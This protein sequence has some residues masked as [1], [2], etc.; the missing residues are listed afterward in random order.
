M[1]TT[2]HRK[3]ASND[4]FQFYEWNEPRDRQSSHRNDKA[5]TQNFKFFVHPR[6]TVLNFLGIWDAIGASRHFTR[7]TAANG[8]EI[9][10]GANL[11]FRKSA[12][13]IEPIEERPTRGM[14]ERTLQH[15]F[16]HPR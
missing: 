6:R 14:C 15:R 9:N 12:K 10:R 11:L 1:S 5:R 2:L 4:F 3:F 13:S 7:K 8:G 16:A